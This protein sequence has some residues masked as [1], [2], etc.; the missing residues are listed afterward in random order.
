MSKR[1]R[2]KL[3]ALVMCLI[4]VLSVIPLNSIPKSKA[5]EA[6]TES[7]TEDVIYDEI[8]EDLVETEDET[9][10]EIATE[11]VAE[12]E[13]TIEEVISEE[14]T[15]EE[16]A[17]TEEITTEEVTTEVAEEVIEEITEEVI[18]EDIT[19]EVT[20]EEIIE[21]E[22]ITEEP[23][24][25]QRFANEVR[26]KGITTYGAGDVYSFNVDGNTY[27]VTY[28]NGEGPVLGTINMNGTEYVFTCSE[29]NKASPMEYDTSII[30][31]FNWTHTTTNYGRDVF[32]NFFQGSNDISW[33]TDSNYYATVS[34]F[35]QSLYNDITNGTGNT[36]PTSADF[37]VTGGPITFTYDSTNGV[38]KSNTLKVTTGSSYIDASIS[39][40]S[41]FTLHYKN[42]TTGVWGSTT[43]ISTWLWGTGTEFYF[44]ASASANLN[45]TV[46]LSA[47]GKYGVGVGYYVDKVGLLS[48]NNTYT[49]Q[50]W[51]STGP[52]QTGWIEGETH[53]FQRL[54]WLI[55]NNKK[56]RE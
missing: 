9:T 15:E 21:E 56:N 39:F 33:M 34:G 20:T 44:T 31:G 48:T 51:G 2:K 19:E 11:D 35:N 26:V 50:V 12:E 27:T 8:S 6:T 49:D 13:V 37:K 25:V 45:G 5:D 46:K 32:W 22:V 7:V 55:K 53:S 18:T 28:Y 14:V 1:T 30:N 38:Q 43:E 3:L 47:S 52:G 40:P 16:I 4:F 23:N 29:P 42:P 36:A 24:F 10:E 41:G 54:A 17:T